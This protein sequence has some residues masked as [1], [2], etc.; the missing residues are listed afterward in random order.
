MKKYTLFSLLKLHIYTCLLCLLALFVCLL[1]AV[2]QARTIRVG[3]YMFDG[4]Q[5]EDANHVRSGYG[6]DF[7]QEMA[8]YTG[9]DYEYVGYDL[10]WA[11]LQEM[12]DRGEI[13]ILTSAR[14]TPERENAYLFST[15]MGTSSGVLN[16]KNGSSR[17]T[18]GDYKTYNSMKVGMIKNS[19]INEN[20]ASFAAAK[21]FTYHP[22]EFFNSDEMSAALQKGDI[23]AICATSLRRS[24]DEWTVDQFDTAY[25]YVMLN[26][27]SAALQQEI[28]AAMEQ[29]DLYSPG[30]R[31]KLNDTYYKQ[32]VGQ[33]IAFT[34][35]EQEFVQTCQDQ[36]Q[37]F[38]VVVA[39][40]N[41]PY[42][43]FEDG[44]AKGILPDIFAEIA[45]R[46]HLQFNIIFTPD[47]E[48]Y[49][50][51]IRSRQAAVRLDCLLNYDAAEKQGYRLTVPYITTP[52]AKV[53]RKQEADT[54]QT[55]ALLKYGINFYTPVLQATTRTAQQKYY[56]S[57][58]HCMEAVAAGQADLTF[59]YPYTAQLYLEEEPG[60]NLSITLLPNFSASFALG[61][62]T[63]A[64]KRLLTI[65][66][67]AVASVK[68]DY[69]N[70]IILSN[71]T[72]RQRPAS[73]QS[74]FSRYPWAKT[75]LAVLVLALLAA[76]VINVIR[77][78]NLRLIEEKN[79]QLQET[80]AE[81][82]EASAAKSDFLSSVSHDMRT[83]LNGIVGFTN[84]AL[85]AQDPAQK[86]AYL[87]KIKQSAGILVDLIND[88]LEV[89]RIESGK[90]T[91]EQE[92]V[93]LPDLIA[94]IAVVIQAAADK[95]Q[96][97][98]QQKLQLAAAKYVYVDHMKLQEVFLN[99]LSNAV[100]YTPA[101]GSVELQVR[102]L[103]QDNGTGQLELKVQDNGI[104]MSQSYLP[105]MFEP[106]T[107]E[108]R[109][110][111]KNTAGTGLGLTIVKRIVDLMQ[112]TIAV[113]S[114]EGK[115]TTFTVTLPVQA[116]REAAA[117]AQTASPVNWEFALTGKKLLLC[118]DNQVNTEIAKTLLE[119]KKMQVVC[120]DNGQRGVERFSQSQP[121]EFAAILMD[122]HMPVL[123]GYA[124]TAKIR[125]L[126]RADAKTI[127]IV[128]MTADAYDEDVRKCLAAG[129][130]GHVAKPIDSEIL[131][132]TLSKVIQ[133][134][135]PI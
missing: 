4:Y 56:P 36:K 99:L 107:Q 52:V 130:N 41:A 50:Q 86:E 129:M 55:V 71:V 128:A 65:L 59:V 123:D 46:S 62:D 104:G 127:P 115:G 103:V 8:R 48:A 84:F 109:V 57:M 82:K 66:N 120:V 9:W 22:V 25:F 60:S 42:A 44:Q 32:N 75:V 119:R 67:K 51:A 98:F 108:N 83:P 102:Q 38:T 29:M 1:P 93:Y 78:K 134:D 121:G 97:K 113:E 37:V 61:V 31:T 124:A 101:C 19:S 54:P 2:A 122:I 49:V 135:Y 16:I 85:A 70:Q 53:S 94:D 80:M 6:Y 63:K 10:G 79:A 73:W 88:T 27:N 133:E 7:L 125:Q 17:V 14:L 34:A 131:L 118:E 64:D 92:W 5:M 74:V 15:Q 35:E 87:V 20:F 45:R 3:Y 26:R 110:Q 13:D 47:R 81:L 89:S 40:E 23:D 18:P 30:W 116:K 11:K 72:T 117:S 69:T 111:L 95:K 76:V 58:R 68:Q 12:L 112:G 21:G 24:N 114:V 126:G 100:K 39:P 91:L 33:E 96:Q 105:K 43:Y 90:F 28:N 106:F 77:Q 132:K